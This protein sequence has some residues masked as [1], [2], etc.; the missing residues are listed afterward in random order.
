MHSPYPGPPPPQ[1]QPLSVLDHH[2]AYAAKQVDVFDS[3]NEEI[4][5]AAMSSSAV[6]GGRPSFATHFAAVTS[7]LFTFQQQGQLC[8][9]SPSIE[10]M[11]NSLLVPI[12]GHFA[13]GVQRPADDE[14]AWVTHHLEPITAP[15]GVP[16]LEL[17]CTIQLQA[18]CV[19]S[20][21]LPPFGAARGDPTSPG[22]RAI[23]VRSTIHLATGSQLR[24]RPVATDRSGFWRRG[25]SRRARAAGT[26]C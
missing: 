8:V 7:E 20:L 21:R 5:A 23:L 13:P 17:R 19:A 22:C 16:E 15:Q 18:A 24:R 12:L 11:P 14:L 2:L 25:Y 6:V 1:Q 4:L 3:L 9:S 10:L 26:C